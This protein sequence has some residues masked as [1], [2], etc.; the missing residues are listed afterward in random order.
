MKK[1]LILIAVMLLAFGVTGVASAAPIQF[2][3][4]SYNV[5]LNT[6]DP[7]LVLYW[8]PLQTTPVSAFL[9]EGYTE[10]FP[11]FR[12]GT[13][14]QSINWDDLAQKQIS[15]SFAWAAPPS[16]VLDDVNGQTYGFID[17][18]R[19]EWGGPAIFTFGNGG[20]FRISLENK[21]FDTPG[22]ADIQATFN[23][24]RAPVPEPMS[25]LLLG[26]GLLGIGVARRKK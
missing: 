21:W 22:F 12:I 1:R 14:E 10:T 2:T 26:L 16:V 7:G 5:N 25:L 6:V 18:G 8:S 24:V 9:E 15:V 17:W 19:V 13:N 4:Q 20:E 23:Y 3:L 11:L